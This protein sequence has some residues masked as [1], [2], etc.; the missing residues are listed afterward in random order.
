[1]IRRFFPSLQLHSFLPLSSVLFLLTS[2]ACGSARAIETAD[3]IALSGKVFV[4]DSELSLVEAFA[5]TNGK[6][7]AVGSN[8]EITKLRGDQTEVIDLQGRMV[9]PGLIDSHV[10]AAA[11][12]MI[13][14]GNTIPDMETIGDVLQY[15]RDRA[16]TTEEGEWIVLRQIFIT[17]LKEQ[18]F[19]TKLELDEAAP[20]HPVAF[21][22]GPDGCL[23][24]R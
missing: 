24:R 21:L 15:V 9:L 13:E 19:P 12:S 3:L 16:A 22:T 10:H 17:R 20:N 14:F 6:F 18:R 5:V 2:I 7:S 4:A 1:M 23:S 8:E 11:A